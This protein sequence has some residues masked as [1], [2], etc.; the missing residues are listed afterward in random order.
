MHNVHFDSELQKVPNVTSLFLGG[1]KIRLTL[2][3]FKNKFFFFIHIFFPYLTIYSWKFF[4]FL[5]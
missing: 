2:E 5:T 3:I 4:L 1:I